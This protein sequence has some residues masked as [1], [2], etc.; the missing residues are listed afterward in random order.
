MFGKDARPVPPPL[1]FGRAS[2]TLI[3][4]LIVIAIIAILSVAVIV[5]LNPAEL[6]RQARDANR[7]SEMDT[8]ER[9]VLLYIGDRGGS[10][11]AASTT[12]F[13]LIDSS[14]TTTAGTN[15]AGVGLAAPGGWSY[16]CAAS[17]TARKTD[18]T[19][20][21]PLNF[22]QMSYKVFPSLPIDPV[23]TSSSGLY[24]AYIP[25]ASTFALTA[26][27]HSTKYNPQT[28]L[29]GGSDASRYEAGSNLSLSAPSQGIVGWWKFEESAGPIADSSSNGNPGTLVGTT[30]LSQAGKVGN[31]ILFN[32]STSYATVGTVAAL[33]PTS[34]FSIL[35]WVKPS[36]I[37][38]DDSYIGGAGSTGNYGYLLRAQSD[39]KVR[40][41]VGNGSAAGVAISTS[42]L[43]NGVWYLVAGTYD[44]SNVRIYVNGVNE[45][46]PA[47][48]SQIVYSGLTNNG[49]FRIAQGDDILPG[50]SWQGT[51]DEVTVYNRVLSA[52][53]IVAVYNASP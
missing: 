17:S 21:L 53:E 35:A 3:E 37:L 19:G 5:T 14:A 11:G 8:M 42:L 7:L 9:A 1:S 40:F 12:Y 52:A 2:F 47:L 26:G 43:S 44:G 10:L 32:G 22:D 4:L 41:H 38:Q 48:A 51:I 24:Y 31:A 50:R 49:A 13:S 29:D 18:G 46:S 34:T 25:A 39:G 33:K 6:L 45:H 36:N 30:T 20:W 16:H 28:V 23:N 15:C 27:L